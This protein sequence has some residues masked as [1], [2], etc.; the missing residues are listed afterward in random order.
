MNWEGFLL[1][2]P[3][4]PRAPSG[5]SFGCPTAQAQEPGSGQD[6]PSLQREPLPQG[7]ANGRGT[8]ALS[9]G[10]KVWVF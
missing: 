3:V 1:N 6:G 8:L 2:W 9:L 10:C 4:Q 7:Q 5:S